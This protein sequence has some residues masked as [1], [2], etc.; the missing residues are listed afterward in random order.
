MTCISYEIYTRTALGC[1]D[2]QVRWEVGG[3]ERVGGPVGGRASGW[4]EGWA[5]RPLPG[6]TGKGVRSECE[7]LIVHYMWH[8]VKCV[9]VWRVHTVG[10]HGEK[11]DVSNRQVHTTG[12]PFSCSSIY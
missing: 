5:Y 4:V 10:M 3:G 11:G 7:K 8:L 6:Q 2:V 12:N 1:I 9:N